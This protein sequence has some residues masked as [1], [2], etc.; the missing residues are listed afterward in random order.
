VSRFSKIDE[1]GA[2]SLEAMP[3]VL[4]WRASPVVLEAREKYEKLLL[5]HLEYLVDELARRDQT[6]GDDLRRIIATAPDQHISR[7]L[8]APETSARLLSPR[9]EPVDSVYDFLKKAFEA[10]V[11]RGGHPVRVS[12]DLWT[13]LGD[14]RIT[15]SKG[16]VC[17][18]VVDGLVPLDFDSPAVSSISLTGDPAMTGLPLDCGQRETTI[19]RLNAARIAISSTSVAAEEL[20]TNLVKVVVLQRVPGALVFS[21]G[22]DQQHIGRVVITNPH[23][24]AVDEARLAEAL[25]HE[26]IHALLYMSVNT[27]PW[28]FID[29]PTVVLASIRSPWTGRQLDPSAFLH[30]CFVWYGLTQFWSLALA[31]G[32]FDSAIA[33]PRLTRSAVGFLGSP[34]LDAIGLEEQKRVISAVAQAVDE[35]QQRVCTIASDFGVKPKTGSS[36]SE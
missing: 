8:T 4:A 12:A 32:T 18:P 23:L 26:A 35:L 36:M 30:A 22:S 6:R 19:N 15:T 31:R 24:P 20:L 1:P 33:V 14:C 11:M 7:V 10:E 34:L 21:S 3:D 5:D 9:N 25:V 13:A 28:G 29:Q 16:A 27:V 2:I 17:A